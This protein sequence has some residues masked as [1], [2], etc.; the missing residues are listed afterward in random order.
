VNT[1]SAIFNHGYEAGAQ[2]ILDGWSRNQKFFRW[3]F[4]FKRVIQIIQCFFL[5]FGPNCSG[6]G[7]KNLKMLKAEP[8]PEILVPAPQP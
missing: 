3:W 2:A 8:E 7:A 6:A 5:I 4:R 1:V